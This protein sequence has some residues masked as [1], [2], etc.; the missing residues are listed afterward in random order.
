MDK[1]IIRD[2]LARGPVGI[3]EAERSCPQDLL[4][5][6]VVSTDMRKAS[7]TDDIADCVSYSKL[8]KEVLHLVETNH[9]KTLEALAADI[10]DLCLGRPL[11]LG[12][13]VRVEKT[14]AVRFTGGTG[15]EIERGRL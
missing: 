12:A 6:L 8:T 13:R 1:V 3:T 15:V 5:N 2:L 10:A 9:R 11:A 4:I 14:S 7:E